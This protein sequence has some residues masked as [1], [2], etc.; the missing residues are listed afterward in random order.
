MG[1]RGGILA[2]TACL[3][4]I[5]SPVRAGET[6]TYTYDELGRLIGV[7]SSGSVNNDQSVAVAFDA[8]GNR[9]NYAV[10]GSSSSAPPDHGASLPSPAPL[11]RYFFNGRF[12]VSF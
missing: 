6:I 12:Y 2:A 3:A 8:A 9:T 10:S 5:S 11:P 1:M 4:L 7:S